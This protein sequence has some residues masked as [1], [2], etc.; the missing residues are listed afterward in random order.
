MKADPEKFGYG[1]RLAVA[2]AGAGGEAV[3]R[4]AGE[5]F[6]LA[7]A[8]KPK[9]AAE[10]LLVWGV[11]LLTGEHAAEAVK[12]FQRG[13]DEKALPDDNPAFYFY[14]AGA[15]AVEKRT[16][17]ALAAAR[18]A[19]EE[20]RFGPLPRP[21]G[22]GALFRQALRRGQRPTASWSASSTPIMPR[23]RPATCCARPGWCCPICASSRATCPRPKSGWNRCSTSSPTTRR[24]ERLGLSVGRSEQEPRPGPADDPA[25]GR[26]RP[27][28]HGLSRQPRLGVVP[29]G[30]IPGGVAEL[31]KAAAGK[32]PDGVVLDHLGDAYLK[33][34]SAATRP[35]RPGARRPQALRGRRRRSKRRKPW[36]RRKCIA[37]L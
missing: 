17:E 20:E 36:R 18:K 31:E 4:P 7:L 11:G 3:S 29:P 24:P 9:Q 5:F 23:R 27:D 1:P 14:L 30:Q 8:T 32:K 10:V 13:I 25:G 2:A 12:V 37:Q 6:E 19:A 15:L 21:R 22:L 35:S 26:R 34:E 28:E 16:E 33:A